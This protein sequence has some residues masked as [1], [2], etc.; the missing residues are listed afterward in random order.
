[1]LLGGVIAFL[2]VFGLFLS[3]LSSSPDPEPDVRGMPDTH[4]VNEVLSE[5]AESVPRSLAA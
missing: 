5:A 2:F 4:S 3:M 1:M